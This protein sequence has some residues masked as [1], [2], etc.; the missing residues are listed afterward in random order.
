[1][2]KTTEAPATYE[3]AYAE[4]QQLVNAL[5]NESV[6]IDE[7]AEKVERAQWLIRFCRER[8]RQVETDVAKLVE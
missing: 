3:T 2:K 5:Q 6:G 1:M 8:L 4:L 7:L